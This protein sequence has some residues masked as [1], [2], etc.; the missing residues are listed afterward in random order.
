MIC[1]ISSSCYYISLSLLF[2]WNPSWFSLEKV[3]INIFCSFLRWLNIELVV[4][5]F[6]WRYIDKQASGCFWL[7][8][9]NICWKMVLFLRIQKEMCFCLFV[10]LLC[11]RERIFHSYG[12]VIIKDEGPV[13]FRLMHG[14]NELLSREGSL[15]CHTC[16]YTKASVFAVSSERNP[17]FSRLL[18]VLRTDCN[19]NPNGLQLRILQIQFG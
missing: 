18:M 3:K 13:K 10:C 2:Y 7:I 9:S 1:E 6:C 14:F 5:Y 17:K 19:T 11:L 4:W 12:N 16:C 15:S 8:R